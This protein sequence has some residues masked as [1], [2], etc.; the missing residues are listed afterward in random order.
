MQDKTCGAVP[1]ECSW[2]CG[3]R[4]KLVTLKILFH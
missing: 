4:G 3:S 2:T 1:G